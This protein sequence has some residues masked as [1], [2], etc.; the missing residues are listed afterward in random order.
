MS[1]LLFNIVLEPLAIGSKE[2]L[3]IYGIKSASKET[4]VTL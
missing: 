4:R 3:N 2:Y 1:P